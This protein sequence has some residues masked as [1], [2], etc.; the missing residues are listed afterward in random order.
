MKHI[1]EIEDLKKT[2]PDSSFELKNISFS[3]PR[4]SIVG[5]IGENG[6][7]KTTTMGTIIGGLKKDSGYIEVLGKEIDDMMIENR[8]NIGV[9]FDD[10]NFSGNLDVYKLSKVMRN[11]YKQWND[12]KFFYYIHKFSLPKNQKI[13]SFSRG[14]SMKL[15]I[16][17]A[18]SHEPKLLILDEATSGLDPV[19][20]EEIL[21]VFLDFVKDQKHAI[22][23][24]SHIISDIQKAADYLVFIKKGEIILTVDKEELLNNYGIVTCGKNE[25]HV[26]DRSNVVTYK[27]NGE[28]AEVLVS[29][30][31]NIPARLTRKSFSIDD[32][33]MLLLKGEKR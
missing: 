13:K 18:L 15:S 3:V 25:L 6:A 12:E 29:N 30:K 8:E 27:Q 32:I 20:R 28:Q 9:V 31:N 26:L 1:L 19:V 5:F 17:V 16:A 11:I 23:L 14:M 10:M 7:G 22:L 21:D 24:S 4:G 33:T 2:Y